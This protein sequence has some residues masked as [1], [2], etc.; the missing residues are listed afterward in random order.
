[1]PLFQVLSHYRLL[2][3]TEDVISMYN[4]LVCAFTVASIMSDSAT[5]WTAA[6]QAQSM[7]FWSGLPYA[8]LQGIFPTQGANQGLLHLLHCRQILYR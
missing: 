6:H 1:M 3:D 4:G 5:L 8:L 7:G 2:Q